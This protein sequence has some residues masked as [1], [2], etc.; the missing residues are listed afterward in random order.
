MFPRFRSFWCYMIAR[1]SMSCQNIS[2]IRYHENVHVLLTGSDALQLEYDW[3]QS[4]YTTVDG[5]AFLFEPREV[6]A[7]T[8]ESDIAIDRY[9]GG[10]A[11]PFWHPHILNK[12]FL[13]ICEHFTRSKG[14]FNCHRAFFKNFRWIK[15]LQNG[16]SDSMYLNHLNHD[17]YLIF[18]VRTFFKNH[19]FM[20]CVTS[21]NKV[22][23]SPHNLYG[24]ILCARATRIKEGSNSYKLKYG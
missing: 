6:A 4:I 23:V 16:Y 5:N 24:K 1:M 10:S 8:Q 7:K 20:S 9:P 15:P 18:S 17:Q 14:C 12:E 19:I 21:S 13:T 11:E 2:Q 3:S 22:C